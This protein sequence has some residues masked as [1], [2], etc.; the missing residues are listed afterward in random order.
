MTGELRYFKATDTEPEHTRLRIHFANGAHLAYDCQ[1]KLGEIDLA[2]DFES[3]IDD[4]DLG[5]D[6]LG[7]DLDTFRERLQAHSAAIKSTLMNQDVIAGIGN[8]YSDEILYQAGIH[9]KTRA[10]R[11]SDKT[12]NQLHRV[13]QRVLRTAIR[14]RGEPE[15][16]P[17]SYMLRHRERGADCPRCGGTIERITVSGRHGLYCPKCQSKGH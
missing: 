17:R 12:L 10:D 11:L 1:R 3:F 8:V 14:H 15:K 5:P 7:I 2:G 16:L 6:A 13:T 9:P 4:H